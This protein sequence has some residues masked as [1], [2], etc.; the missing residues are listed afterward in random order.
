PSGKLRHQLTD[1]PEKIAAL[2]FSPDNSTLASGG[3]TKRI[4]LW[5]VSTGKIRRSLDG[6][7]DWVNALAFSPD[8]ASLASASCDWGY[9]RGH[10]WPRSPSRGIEQAEWRLWDLH[11]GQLL[12]TVNESGQMLS[13]AFSPNGKSLACSLGNDVRLYDVAS[14]SPTRIV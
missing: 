7:R 12:R 3:G 8:G 2:A 1:Q 6:H 14:T 10:D 4:D 5:D 9:H 11:S 13:L